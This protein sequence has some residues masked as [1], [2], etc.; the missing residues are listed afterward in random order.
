MAYV[1]GTISTSCISLLACPLR[2]VFPHLMIFLAR[3][4]K[5]LKLVDNSISVMCIGCHIMKGLKKD[6]KRKKRT[7]YY[8]TWGNASACI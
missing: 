1:I 4:L 3:G 8:N 2:I 6:M 7:N 5:P